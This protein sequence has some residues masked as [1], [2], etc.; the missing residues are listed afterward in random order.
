[1]KPRRKPKEAALELVSYERAQHDVI[2]PI[3]TIQA[4]VR[5]G[6]V[7]DP[8]EYY[9]AR[10]ELD[11]LL[12]EVCR[13]YG[14]LRYAAGLVPAAKACGMDGRVDVSGTAGGP[15]NPS[16]RRWAALRR[17]TRTDAEI[18]ARASQVHVDV[19]AKV[20]AEGWSAAAWAMRAGYRKNGAGLAFLRD[21]AEIV[22]RIWGRK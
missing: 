17:L 2:V 13:D 10:G 22:A 1:M 3:E 6:R 14:A 5:A 19:L 18:V 4:G 12:Y 15:L 7:R 8:L 16:E 9:Q 11:A 20:C 21:G